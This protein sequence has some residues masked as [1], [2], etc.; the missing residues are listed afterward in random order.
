MPKPSPFTTRV[1]TGYDNMDMRAV[2]AFLTQ[3]YWSKGVAFEV[4]DR[5][6]R[7]SLC[8]GLFQESRQIGFAR[9]VTDKATF[10][11]L[12]DVYVMEAHRGQGLA[13]VLLDAVF[14]HPDVQG[15]RNFLLLTRDAHGLYKKYG[16]APFGDATRLME[17]RPNPT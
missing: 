9:V 11:Y 17:K 2:H 3:A 4:V 1:V 8:F 6:A 12:A 10:A 16:F 14:A 7:H 15:L 13:R 5:A